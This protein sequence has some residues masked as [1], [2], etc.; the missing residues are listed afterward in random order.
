MDPRLFAVVLAYD[1]K[2]VLSTLSY[3]LL[4]VSAFVHNNKTQKNTSHMIYI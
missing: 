1:N 2:T 3:I 4:V